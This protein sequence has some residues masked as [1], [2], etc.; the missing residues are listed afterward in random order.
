MLTRFH[1]KTSVLAVAAAIATGSALA[2]SSATDVFAQAE[3]PLV[4][5]DARVAQNAPL[6]GQLSTIALPNFAAITEQYGPA[7]VN[8]SVRGKKAKPSK[9]SMPRDFENMPGLPEMFKRFGIPMPEQRGRSPQGPRAS[10]QGSGFIVSQDGLILTNAHVVG[11]SEDVTVRMTDRREYAAKVLGFD[12]RTDVAVLKIEASDLPTVKLGNPNALR[13][14]QWVAAIGSP[15]G[16]EN[17]VTVGV[18]SAKGRSLPSDGI[19]PFIQTDVAV[20]PGNSGGPLINAA[21]EVIG[22]NSQ[23]F[24]RTGGYQGLSFAIPI[25]MA[26]QV[27]DQITENGEVQHARLGVLIQPVN[28]KLAQAFGLDRPRGALVSEV[29]PDSAAQRAG[30]RAGDIILKA[31]DQTIERSASLPAIVSLSSPKESM[32]FE[33]WRDKKPVTIT[34]TPT[35]SSTEKVAKLDKP[36]TDGEQA[37]KL[38][39]SL[40]QLEPGDKDATGRDNGLVVVDVQGAAQRAG[41]REGDV[42]LQVNGVSV[43]SID[44]IREQLKTVDESVAILIERNKRK[45]YVP[46]PVG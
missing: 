7:V 41:I 35:R 10:G 22:I 32:T 3:P 2:L 19:V 36:G 1:K 6:T 27:Q 30:L 8:V 17:T 45:T 42:V 15:F 4:R 37:P 28:D 14:G 38:G 18:V 13:P 9:S 26:L 33:I 39:L 34:A 16:F 11:N 46:V 40:R 21:G 5:S 24:S 20:N 12:T 25:D 44:E 31:N 29:S 43:S 23:I